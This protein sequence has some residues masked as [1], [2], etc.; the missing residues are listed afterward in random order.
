MTDMECGLCGRDLA[1]CTCGITITPEMRE[2]VRKALDK[3]FDDCA[4]HARAEHER[5][6]SGHMGMCMLRVVSDGD[7]DL[8]IE[9]ERT[10]S[11]L[12]E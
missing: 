12:I 1:D 9:I 6:T 2:G 5:G 10:I 7:G 8:S 4:K 11:E 3:W